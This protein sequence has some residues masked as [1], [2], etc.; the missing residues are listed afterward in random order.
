MTISINFGNP[1]AD[2]LTSAGNFG[3]AKIP[4]K[5]EK[6]AWQSS[7]SAIASR[8]ELE[9]HTAKMPTARKL[10]ALCA[11]P[12]HVGS[13]VQSPSFLSGVIGAPK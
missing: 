7:W 5:G 2:Q 6:S 1:G 4:P 9:L 3:I 12:L 11:E 13:G 10:T 8:A